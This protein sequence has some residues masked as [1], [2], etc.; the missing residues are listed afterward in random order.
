[1][2]TQSTCIYILCLV[3]FIPFYAYTHQNSGKLGMYII[4]LS[5][6]YSSSLHIPT[7][8][9]LPLQA[10]LLPLITLTIYPYIHSQLSLFIPTYPRSY[11]YLPLQL[12]LF[13]PY[14]PYV[15]ILTPI[16]AGSSSSSSA[17]SSSSSSSSS[18][19]SLSKVLFGMS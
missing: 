8:P 15:S 13:T 19:P 12:S 10:S 17:S 9:H 16:C 3:T 14:Y 6:P 11:S 7:C 5:Y 18:S 2:P 1:M 4:R